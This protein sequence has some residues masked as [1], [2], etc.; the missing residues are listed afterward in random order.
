MTTRRILLTVGGF[1]FL[2]A[3][4]L[5]AQAMKVTCKDGTPSKGGQGACSS[6]GGIASKATVKAHT[7]AVASAVKADTKALKSDVKADAN[8]AKAEA[9]SDAKMMKHE[10]KA[11]AKDMKAVTTAEE[12]DAK[13]ATAMCKDNTYSHAKN[14]QGMCSAH[15]GVAKLIG[16]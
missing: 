6:H 16:K 15:G 13:G 4:S 3:S 14:R 2:S 9:K 10:T 7:K 12:K 1:L 5:S 11:A 8:V